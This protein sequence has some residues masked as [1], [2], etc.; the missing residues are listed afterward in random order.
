VSVMR[1]ATL[2]CLLCEHATEHRRQGLWVPAFARTTGRAFVR[3]T[4]LLS[5]AERHR[6]PQIPS[7]EWEFQGTSLS[8]EEREAERRKAHLGN[9][10]GLFPGLPGNRG[11]R[12]RLSASRR[13]GFFV[14]RTVLPSAGTSRS[15]SS[16]QAFAHPSPVSSSH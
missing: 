12:Q 4:S 3:I 15:P 14:P 10:R 2:V 8:K 11:T 9:G 6:C 16:R 5:P 7:R 13:G 1:E